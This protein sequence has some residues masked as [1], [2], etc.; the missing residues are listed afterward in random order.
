M[1]S[2]EDLGQ[3][4]RRRFDR[5]VPSAFLVA[6]AFVQRPGWT[7]ADTKLD[8]VVDPGGFLGR[9][10]SLWDPL[11]AG[12]Q[13]QN[14]AYGY[15]FPMGPFFWLGHL[16][17]VPAWV[18]QRLWWALILLVAY[19]GVLGVLER[20]GIGTRWSRIIGAASY[21]LAPRMLIGLGAIS[22]E[23]WPMAVAPWILLPLLAVPPGRERAAALRSGAAILLLGA[24][25]AVASLAVLVLPLWWLLTRRA[26]ARWTLLGWWSAAVLLATAWWIGPLVLLGR[27]S[28]P[29]LDWIEDAR[30]TTAVASTTE[31]LRGTTQWIATI[32]GGENAVWPAGWVVLSSR[33]VIL[34]GLTVVLAGM[35]GLAVAR[36]PW[37]AFARGGLVIGLLLVTFGHVG[38]VAPP[39]AGQE[40]NL[41]DGLLAPFRN[42][43]KFEPVVR[44]PLALGVAYG[45]PLTLPWLRARGAPWPGIAT[46]LV[47]VALI[48]QTAAPAFVGVIQ[49]GEFRTVPD[50]WSQ[51]AHW[52]DAHPDAGRALVLPGGNAPARLWGEPKDEPLQPF[53][54]QPW[55]VRDAVPLGSAGTTR[56]LDEIEAVVAQG[57]GGPRLLSLLDAL[58]VTRVVLVGDHQRV[59]SATTPPV[60]VRSA[61]VATGARSVASFGDLVGG[62]RNL[63]V[64]SDWGLDRPVRELEVFD[65]PTS[66]SIAPTTRVPVTSVTSFSGGPEGVA[67]LPGL[68]PSVFAGDPDSTVTANPRTV[69]SDTLQRRQASFATAT[70]LYGPLLSA[71]EAYPSPRSTHDYWPEPLSEDDPDLARHQ[72]VRVDDGEAR[73]TASSTLAEPALGQG[74]ELASQAWRAFD[75]SGSTGWR[76][77]GY[78]ARGQ[79]V[80]ASWAVPT[81]LPPLITVSFDT[82][83]G[84]DVAAVSVVTSAGAARTPVTSPDLAGD[85]DAAAYP[86]SV[87]VPPGA[88]TSLRLVIEAVRD[89][90]PT[91]RV[92]DIGSGAVPRVQPRV[93]LPDTTT[94]PDV[95]ALQASP[96]DRS[97][98]YPLSSAVLTCS[99]DRRRVGEEATIMRRQLTLSQDRAFAVDGTVVATA[100]AA[101]SLLLRLDGVRAKGSSRWIPEPG[102]SALLA[103]DGDPKT[104]WAADP[105]DAEPTLSVSWPT[106]RV[107]EGLRFSVDPDVAGRRP[108]EVD[109][110]IG[111][112]TFHR[113]LDR[114]G[115]LDLPRTSTTA[116]EV[117]V[118]HTTPQRSFTASGEKEMPV[119]IGDLDLIGE[120]W[121]P[122]AADR[123]VVVPC[124]FGPSLQV[125]GATFATTVTATRSGILARADVPLRVC[126]PVALSAGQ[127]RLQTYASREFAVRSLT[128]DARSP[129]ASGQGTPRL[130]VTATD[131]SASQRSVELGPAAAEETLLVVRENENPGWVATLGK[132]TLR[133]VRVDGWSQGWVVPAGATGT[134]SLQFAPQRFFV[135]TL[136]A[137]L[138]MAIAL[139]ALTL[140]SRPVRTGEVVPEVCA[141]A[142]GRALVVVSLVAMG[143]MVGAFAAGAAVVA[144]RFGPSRAAGVAGA[145]S[146]GWVAWALFRP[147]PSGDTNRDAVSGA[148]A[149]TVL[150]LATLGGVRTRSDGGGSA[151]RPRLD[152]GLEKVPAGSGHERGEREGHHDGHPEAVREDVETQDL[153]D[154]EHDGEVPQEDSVADGAQ[155]DQDPRGQDPRD[156]GPGAEH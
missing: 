155:V 107:V 54:T 143:G 23:I 145:F 137:G 6:L 57:R 87:T 73:A 152:R 42:T 27:Y 32:G 138:A 153:A 9:A 39:W 135:L 76:S 46:A 28:P 140:R 50:A 108:T 147:W 56:V 25:N 3:L 8:L 78:D 132:E 96:D 67:S 104:Y 30:V 94:A 84:A 60:V 125:N 89:T 102:V 15:L 13:L 93:R 33:N 37:T 52:M 98:C 51:A 141:P 116:L 90:K 109:V 127:Q 106:P 71:H 88:T 117:A 49:R 62:S 115:M 122:D 91:V 136:L 22:S 139:L 26:P 148:F 92:L 97:A 124:G 110:T 103:V 112:Q 129:T 150:A 55:I 66:A 65:V 68:R 19:H 41:L 113:V 130:S 10:L 151:T 131:W 14:Q 11:A 17:Q 74:R 45:L 34:L 5:I 61:L 64:A 21:A 126:L 47:V 38:G 75:L 128:L 114:D 79:W 80:Q 24:V 118:T 105:G 1:S 149:L 144:A 4:W 2:P 133:P 58:A 83:L 99:P 72:T 18:V 154:T 69:T 86:V 77:A 119:V 29:F 36:G 101:D 44:L 85:V 53:A 59:R 134:V 7:A 63:T 120:G 35:A 40:A 20:L 12:G 123:S 70:D 121:A 146:L 111:K 16:L 100:D 43:H 82:A 142:L 48:G 95:V 156:G 31:A 81:V